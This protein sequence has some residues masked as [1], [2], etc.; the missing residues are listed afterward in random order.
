MWIVYSHQY[1]LFGMF[2]IIWQIKTHDL[3]EGNKYRTCIQG[4]QFILKQFRFDFFPVFIHSDLVNLIFVYLAKTVDVAIII[5][6]CIDECIVIQCCI[7]LKGSLK[8]F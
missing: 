7:V 1:A 4:V 3:F 6:F 2:S 5:S 8:G